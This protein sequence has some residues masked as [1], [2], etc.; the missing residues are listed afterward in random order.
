V[1]GAPCAALDHAHPEGNGA[2]PV[3]IEGLI[4]AAGAWGRYGHLDATLLLL[5]SRHGLRVSVRWDAVDLKAGCCTCRGS[6][7]E[8]PKPLL[9]AIGRAVYGHL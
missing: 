6:K 9:A 1:R 5:A 3:V 2:R 8:P 7:A 4:Q